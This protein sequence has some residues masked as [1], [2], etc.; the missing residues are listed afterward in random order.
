MPGAEVQSD[1]AIDAYIRDHVESAY[2]PC[3]ACRI[4][5]AADPN[6]VVD[7]QCRVIGIEALRI[8]DASIIP[9]VTNGNLNAPCLMLGEKASDHILGREPLAASN[10]E[11]W[12]HPAWKTAQR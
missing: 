1:E 12:V 7:P 3:G 8:A 4:G 5:A 6:A 2:H 11:P 9:M 10:Q